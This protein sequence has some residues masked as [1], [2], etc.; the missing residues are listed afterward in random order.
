MVEECSLREL[1]GKKVIGYNLGYFGVFLNNMLISVFAFQFYVY[2]INLSP[3]LAAI[4]LSF[5][6]VLGALFSI[7]FGVAIDNKTPGKRGKRR[8]FLLY[9]LPFWVLSNLFLWIPPLYCPQNNTLFFP[10]A[11]YYWIMLI[12]IAF[13]GNMILVAHSSMLPEQAQT[14]ENRKMIASVG[15]MLNIIASFIAMLF[16]LIIQSLLKEPENVKWWQSSGKTIIFLMPFVGGLFVI[17]GAI[18]IL[19]TYFSVDESFLNDCNAQE[20]KKKSISKVFKDMERP[21]KDKKYRKFV[22]ANFFI[23]F[24][25]R[26]IALALMPFLIYVL[27]F[28]GP[29]FFLY[30]A[31]SIISKLTWYYIW[32]A[33][34]K[35]YEIMK[36]FSISLAFAV[37]GSAFELLFLIEFFSF[38]L[39]F[40]IFFVT[41]GTV[42][43][44]MYAIGLFQ[45]PIIS[46]LID[47][48]ALKLKEKP[49]DQAVSEIAGSYSGLN[50]F[51]LTIGQAFASMIIGLMLIGENSENP[52]IITLIMA[53]AGLS[54]LLAFLYINRISL[55][56][57]RE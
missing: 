52:V 15:T 46:A 49:K 57:R 17:F 9:A 28:F 24:S 38:E 36:T 31:V 4:G 35:R 14:F 11:L 25:A 44:T 6:L 22:F 18:S 2:T 27:L 13:F 45:G 8:L 37:V 19:T 50:M 54:Y 39:R 29:Q 12:L 40:A 33:V 23:Q 51:M 20:L 42:M 56:N 7:V 1:H 21:A 43:G 26:V 55:D 34:L 5:Q 48:A 53:S 41:Y 3:I 47:E 10:V 32:K 30:M 16:P